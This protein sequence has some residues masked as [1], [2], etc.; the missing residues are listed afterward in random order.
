MV[1]LF[2]NV[3]HDAFS[4]STWFLVTLQI[5]IAAICAGAFG[6]PSG[7]LGVKIFQ[8]RVAQ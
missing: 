6:A 5:V 8:P 7:I 4:P 3:V 1:A 2:T